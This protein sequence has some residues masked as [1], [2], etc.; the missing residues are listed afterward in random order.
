M[1]RRAVLRVGACAALVLLI[2]GCKGDHKSGPSN[3]FLFEHNA[4]F[5]GGRTIRWPVL[6]IRVFLGNGVA[7]PDEV[8]VWT[9]V[10]GGLV[11]FVFVSSAGGANITFRFR[12]GDDICGLTVVE[13]TDDGTIVA[14]D[15]Q[16]SRSIYRGRFC[17]R[18]VTH[19]TA[20]A[21]GF[22]SHTA[23]GGLMDDDGGN[24]EI[25]PPVIQF[26][27]DLYSLPPGTRVSAAQQRLVERRAGGRNSMTFIHPVRR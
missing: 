17:V 25:T 13:F 11:T 22:L 9:A 15:V 23:D 16:V 8:A 2:L 20:H 6:P 26:F 7:S 1:R 24:G 5:L 14:A 19:E 12:G 18:T 10:T 3:S 4:Q 27:R 21:I